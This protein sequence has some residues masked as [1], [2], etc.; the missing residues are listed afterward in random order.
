MCPHDTYMSATNSGIALLCTGI[1]ATSS[2][3]SATMWKREIRVVIHESGIPQI[4]RILEGFDTLFHF[5]ID[6]QN[7]TVLKLTRIIIS[8]QEIQSEFVPVT[9]DSSNRDKK[10]SVKSL[11]FSCPWIPRIWTRNP[12]WICI[13]DAGFLEPEQ[14]IQLQ[15]TLM[16]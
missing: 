2:R 10:S 7:N 12:E 4:L 11:V 1:S 5:S 9:L 16:I 15:V 8:G 6:Y 3:I 14:E 13:R